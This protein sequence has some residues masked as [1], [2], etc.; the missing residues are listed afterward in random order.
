MRAPSFLLPTIQN[1]THR[2]GLSNPFVIMI[3]GTRRALQGEFRGFY[4]GFPIMTKI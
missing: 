1:A 2:S 4:N 3:G